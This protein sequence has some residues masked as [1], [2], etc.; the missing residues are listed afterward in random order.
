MPLLVKQRS[1]LREQSKDLQQDYSYFDL[2]FN[3]F[4]IG[5]LPFYLAL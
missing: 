5:H 4:L 2:Y 3:V 1:Y